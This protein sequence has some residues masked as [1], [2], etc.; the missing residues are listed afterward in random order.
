MRIKSFFFTNNYLCN[1]PENFYLLKSK[2]NDIFGELF[3][4]IHLPIKDLKEFSKF[5]FIDIGIT[6][7]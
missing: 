6:C 7:L 2:L 3:E 1:F 4:F 5:G